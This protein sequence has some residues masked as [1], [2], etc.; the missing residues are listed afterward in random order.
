MSLAL[1]KVMTAAVAAHAWAH[2]SI[3]KGSFGGPTGQD[4]RMRGCKNSPFLL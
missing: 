3:S 2:M 4:N 1:Q